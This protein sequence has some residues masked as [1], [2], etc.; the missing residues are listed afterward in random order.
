MRFTSLTLLLFAFGCGDADITGDP[1]IDLDAIENIDGQ[2]LPIDADI[3]VPDADITVP[4]A[5]A[6]DATPPA[7]ANLEA[8]QAFCDRYETLCTYSADPNRFDDEATCLTAYESFD[9]AQQT[10]VEDQLDQLEVDSQ[11]SHCRSAMGRNPC[12]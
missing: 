4:D 11:L 3:T 8:A 6:I 9:A 5:A 7:D 10:C 2:I 1:Q 12:Q